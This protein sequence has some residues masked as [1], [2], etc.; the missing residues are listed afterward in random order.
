[1]PKPGWPTKFNYFHKSNVKNSRH[2][3]AH[4]GKRKGQ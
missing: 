2:G 1:M 3:G 4:G